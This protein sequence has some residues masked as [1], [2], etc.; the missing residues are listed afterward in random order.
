VKKILFSF[1]LIGNSLLAQPNNNEAPFAPR[2]PFESEIISLPRT[3]GDFS[4]YYIYKIPYRMLVFERKVE[5][6]DAGF[7]VTVEIL[8][9]DSKLV[10]RD[11]KDRKV[12]VNNFEETNDYNFFLQDYLSF[13][14]KPGE[15]KI[16]ALISDMNSTGE[17]QLEPI[18]L[19]LEEY[20]DKLVQHPLV[21]NS[22]EMICDEKKAFTLANSGG[23][24]PFSSD[25]FH[26]IIPVTDTSITEIDVIIEN[27]DEVIISTKVNESYVIP[28][29]IAECE[30]H[31]SVTSNPETVALRNFVLRNV[32]DKLTEG[33]VV[34]KVANEEKSID[35]KY[36]SKIVWFNKPFSLTDPEKAIEFLNFVESD[37]T[38]YSLLGQ[39][40]SDY[41]KL[42]N[43]Y[44]AKFDPTPETAY[45]E[46]MFE[47]YSRVDYSVKEFRGIGKDNGAKTDR[48]VVYIKFGKPE[49]IERTSNPQGQMIEIWTYS[50]PE[51]QFS[52]ID[53]KG[54]GNFTLTEN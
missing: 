26:L 28:V 34:L 19:E 47:Y 21:I 27:N 6:F 12:I 46:I 45:N 42:L 16:T 38:V 30:G 43:N 3:D 54:T 15:Y 31:L 8:D 1:F 18:K 41:P 10:A 53:Q 7:R 9:D 32:N 51:R 5:S 20:E 13:K 17:L 39:S 4:V 49:K 11:I 35:E 44:W 29:G 33:E 2:L 24:V 22:Q 25:K 37:S 50:N 23:N 52:F 40:S 48:G 36:K 14:L